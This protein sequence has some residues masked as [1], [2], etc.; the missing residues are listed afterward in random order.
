MIEH[1]GML[2]LSI[3]FYLCVYLHRMLDHCIDTIRAAT[4]CTG[5]LSTYTYELKPKPHGDGMRLES[6]TKAE[7]RC[8]KLD[9]VMDWVHARQLPREMA[10]D[11]D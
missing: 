11:V 10:V 6:K 2:P 9:P 5:D 8:I 4:M 7:R 1:I 3:P